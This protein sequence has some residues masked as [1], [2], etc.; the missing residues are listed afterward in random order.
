MSPKRRFSTILLA[1]VP[2]LVATTGCQLFDVFTETSGVVDVFATSHGSPDDEGNV[3][4]RNSNQIIFVNDMGWEVFIDEAVITT[5][6]VSLERCDGADNF[7]VELY[8]GALAE[9]LNAAPDFDVTGLGGV[10]VDSGDY[11]ELLV[12]FGPGTEGEGSTV[13]LAGSA[14][15]GDTHVD[16]VW[17]SNMAIE[18]TVDISSVEGGKPFNISS[19]ENFS[20]KLTI[21]KDYTRFFS[22]V[23][24]SAE[25]SQ[26]EIDDLVIATLDE[27][28]FAFPGTDAPMMPPKP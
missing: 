10:R 24:F 9:D 7:D 26:A 25:L 2:T 17:Q 19:S 4:D 12:S 8:W 5:E 14:I 23:D 11:C 15:N 6:G 20:K 28:T 27:D 3:P 1:V 13:Y 18:A 21:T 22:G 16:F